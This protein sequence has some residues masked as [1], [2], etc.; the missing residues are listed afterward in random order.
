[1][2]K[3]IRRYQPSRPKLEKAIN[4]ILDKAINADSANAPKQLHLILTTEHPEWKLPERRVA[5]Y[6][7]RQLKERKN[8]NYKKIDADLD[9]VSLYSTTSTSTW[10]TSSEAAPDVDA[11]LMSNVVSVPTTERAEVV[12]ESVSNHEKEKQKDGES[13][14]DEEGIFT[15][16]VVP[17]QRS[18]TASATAQIPV[19]VKSEAVNKAY[20]ED[21][22]DKMEEAPLFC[23]G[24]KCIIS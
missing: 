13:V 15:K 23:E 3:R 24:V 1:M 21:D 6:L 20:Y 4:D 17:T 11:V 9:E 18:T 10:R 5:K 14:K 12:D 2:A 8:M 22:T 7:K 16:V 19:P